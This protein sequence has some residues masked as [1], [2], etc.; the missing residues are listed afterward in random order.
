MYKE[1]CKTTKFIDFKIQK[2]SLSMTIQYHSDTL[3]LF[4]SLMG[5]TNVCCPFPWDVAHGIPI[6]IPFPL[7]KPMNGA[8]RS[9]WQ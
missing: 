6:G 9:S 3:I 8:H 7:D 4:V 2:Y 5:N 1:T